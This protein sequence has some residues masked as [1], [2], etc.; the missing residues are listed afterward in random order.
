MEGENN[1]LSV[2][3]GGM[4]GPSQFQPTAMPEE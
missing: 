3:S 2:T 4:A 1:R